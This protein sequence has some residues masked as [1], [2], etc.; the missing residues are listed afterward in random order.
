MAEDTFMEAIRNKNHTE[1]ECWINTIYDFYKDTLLSEN[2]RKQI[3]RATIL[4]DIGM[5]EDTIKNG[6]SANNILPCFVKYKLQLRVFDIFGKLVFMYDP[7]IKSH[8]NKVMY[9]LI[10]GNHAYTLNHDLKALQQKIQTPEDKHFISK[11]SPNY[12]INDNDNKKAIEYKMIEHVNDLLQLLEI[13]KN[14]NNEKGDKK[15]K[16]SL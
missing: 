13:T 7:P 8:H 1:N 12:H 6:I 15:Y 3:T 5:T 9:C 11:A 14:T 16:Y 4:N 2:K 10:K